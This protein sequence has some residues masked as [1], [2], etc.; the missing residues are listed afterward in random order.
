MYVGGWAGTSSILL[1]NL[2]TIQMGLIDLILVLVVA[3]LL[4]LERLFFEAF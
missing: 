4:E 2:F 1:Y 3:Y